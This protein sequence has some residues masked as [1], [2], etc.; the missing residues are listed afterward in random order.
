MWQLMSEV[1]LDWSDHLIGNRISL[2][3]HRSTENR[4]DG[5]VTAGW[6]GFPT[7]GKREANH[8]E[9]MTLMKASQERMGAIQE[10]LRVMDLEVN[11]E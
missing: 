11:P 2:L 8:E 10:K 9:L 3:Y 4:T 5:G 1:G 7:P 6:D